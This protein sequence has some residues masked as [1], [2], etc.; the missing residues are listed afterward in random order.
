MVRTSSSLRSLSLL[1]LP[2]LKDGVEEGTFGEK[3]TEPAGQAGTLGNVIL[4]VIKAHSVQEEL[5][6]IFF[7][8][9]LPVVFDDG[10]HVLDM[11]FI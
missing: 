9:L 10:G 11:T 5:D 6:S 4:P 7:S 2:L 3:D 1:L 8:E